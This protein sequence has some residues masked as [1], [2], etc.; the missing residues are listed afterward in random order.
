MHGMLSCMRD[1]ARRA[2]RGSALVAA[3]SVALIVCGAC[4]GTAP[5]NTGPT[6]NADVLVAVTN[7]GYSD[8]EIY[9]LRQSTRYHIGFVASN[10]TARLHVPAGALE[11]SGDLQLVVHRIGD[12]GA[13]YVAETIHVEP[14]QLAAFD[15]EPRVELS[16]LSVRGR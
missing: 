14:D 16:T 1:R 9:A 5:P 2:A 4:A 7:D 15:I 8:A 10:R 6:M 12:S 3:V 13:D 11:A